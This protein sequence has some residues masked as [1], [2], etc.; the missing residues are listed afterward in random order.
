MKAV[1]CQLPPGALLRRY[2]ASRD[3]T[4]CFVI[5]IGRRIRLEE[6]V[7]AFYTTWVF[8]IE[9]WILA[10]AVSRTSTDSAARE[11]AAGS[12]SEFA[13]WHV[14]ARSRNQLL[15][16]DYRGSTRSWFMSEEQAGGSGVRLY[17]GS[18]IISSAR[19]RSGRK[20]LEARFRVLLGFHRL[21]SR[22]LLNAAGR[23]LKGSGAPREE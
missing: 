8:R 20:R 23:R 1:A 21:Y 22:V 17:F 13:A 9:R 7:A 3:Y 15:M 19:D 2:A 12:I 16:A 11:V 6:F 4:D 5:E 10:W 18:A 14:E